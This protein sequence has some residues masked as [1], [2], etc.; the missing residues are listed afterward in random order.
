MKDPAKKKEGGRE[1]RAEAERDLDEALEASFPASD[2][3]P[4]TGTFAGAPDEREAAERRR[5]PHG[6]KTK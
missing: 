2:P 3:L 1:K 6:G 4:T 5:R